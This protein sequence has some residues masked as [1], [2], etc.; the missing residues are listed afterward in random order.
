MSRTHVEK[1]AS[2]F[3]KSLCC[4]VTLQLKNH[5]KIEPMRLI[6]EDAG[7]SGTVKGKF[8]KFKTEMEMIELTF[9]LLRVIFEGEH[10]LRADGVSPGC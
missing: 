2:P 6:I 8:L 7:R 10:K 9:E 3:L 5:T 4:S 1:G